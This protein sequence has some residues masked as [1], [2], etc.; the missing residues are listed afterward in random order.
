MA[1]YCEYAMNEI[2]DDINIY[3]SPR[4]YYYEVHYDTKE[5]RWS[6]QCGYYVLRGLP[7]EHELAICIRY[8]YSIEKQI[9]NYW[10]R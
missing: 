9:S 8:N 4:E 2:D 10:M 7:C 1:E 6:C 3:K 5:N